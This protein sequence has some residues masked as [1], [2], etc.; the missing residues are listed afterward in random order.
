[1]E[2][3]VISIATHQKLSDLLDALI[4]EGYFHTLAN[5]ERYTHNIYAFIYS[6]PDQQHQP[7][8]KPRYGAFYSK[9]K[10]NAHTTYYVVFD[11]VDGVYYVNDI[12]NNHTREYAIYIKSKK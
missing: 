11:V 1:M 12:F 10:A 8:S 2:E 5:A 7:L 4:N 3:V 9:Y 6:I